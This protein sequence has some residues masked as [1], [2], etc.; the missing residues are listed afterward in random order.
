M[1]VADHV[2]REEKEDFVIESIKDI[3]IRL[4]PD[5]RVQCPQQ[6]V[7]ETN[8]ARLLEDRHG[9][10]TIGDRLDFGELLRGNEDAMLDH[11]DGHLARTER[12]VKEAGDPCDRQSTGEAQVAVKVRC[13]AIEALWL[14]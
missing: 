5:R 7:Y 3:A 12:I 1:Q 4:R 13:N 6:V 8:V 14:P 11:I 2:L 10:L 9:G